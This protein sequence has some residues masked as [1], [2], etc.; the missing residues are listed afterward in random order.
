MRPLTDTT[1]KPLLRVNDKCLIEYRIEALRQAGIYQLVIN[2]GWLGQQI[3]DTL[4]DGSH[5]GVSIEYSQ[6]PETAYETGGGIFYALQKLSDPF[7]VVNSDIWT[8]YNFSQLLDKPGKLAHLI[9]VDNPE[10][11]SGGDFAIENGYAR[12][13]GSEYLTFSGI[14]VYRKAM[15]QNCK[16]G[17]FPLAPILKNHMGKNEIT[18]EHYAGIWSD[19]GTLSRLQHISR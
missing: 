5:Y 4:G 3:E 18:A 15:F 10:Y 13:K 12:S 6:E 7:I 19:I 14:G 9:L 17:S 2:T 16:A 11:Y 1:P 8:D